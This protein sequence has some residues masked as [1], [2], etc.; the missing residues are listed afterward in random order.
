MNIGF[1][2]RLSFPRPSG[3]GRYAVTLLRNLAVRYGEHEFFAFSN[4]RAPSEIVKFLQVLKIKDCTGP[5][6]KVITWEQCVLPFLTR[7]HHI[8]LYHNTTTSACP[9]LMRI[10]QVVTVHDLAWWKWPDLVTKPVRN[11]LKHFF[12]SVIKRSRVIIAVSET[13][14]QDLFEMIGR[15]DERV[16]VIPEG[17]GEE[18]SPASPEK[19]SRTKNRY[20]IERPYLLYVGAIE[21]RK[22]IPTLIQAF[23]RVASKDRGILLVLAGG[24][25]WLNQ[26]VE[27]LL[28]SSPVR[29]NILTIGYVAEGDLPALYSGAEAFV[30]PS[31]YEG[32]GLPILEAMAC[33]C[34]VV[35][36][37]GGAL[38]EVAG[39]AAMIF[40]SGDSDACA[41]RIARLRESPTERLRYLSQ[42]FE[43]T[44]LFS[45]QK[46]ADLTFQIYNDVLRT[47]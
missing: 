28:A 17:V 8:D 32:F 46:S 11:Y 34:P 43:R 7:R 2:V 15:E 19:I 13:T 23:N 47:R 40:P 44:K 4:Y 1:D 42:G 10:P 3:V 5:A 39:K 14:R 12:P 22:D 26:D 35:C 29:D 16:L 18:F 31:R 37:D 25:G 30:M 21:P 27:K 9:A 33:G 6:L 38:S 24:Q 41:E 36:S 20:G 45:W